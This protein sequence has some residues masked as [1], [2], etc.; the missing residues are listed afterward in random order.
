MSTFGIYIWAWGIP[1][2]HV[3]GLGLKSNWVVVFKQYVWAP[4]FD[5]F[6]LKTSPEKFL[7]L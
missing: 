5:P 6:C 1:F 3:F 7:G 4:E 2:P